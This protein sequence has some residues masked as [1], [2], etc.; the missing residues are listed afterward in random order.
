MVENYGTCKSWKCTTDINCSRHEVNLLL[1][2]HNQYPCP[3]VNTNTEQRQ[4]ALRTL[5]NS[6]DRWQQQDLK[7]GL[8]LPPTVPNSVCFT[9][10]NL[11]SCILVHKNNQS[12]HK[13]EENNKVFISRINR[14]KDAAFL[15]VRTRGAYSFNGVFQSTYFSYKARRVRQATWSSEQLCWP[16]SLKYL[17]VYAYPM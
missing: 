10:K 4:C 2:E 1:E 12:V 15:Y 6:A 13:A 8:P 16:S 11:V 14:W 3:S 5:R 9:V 17:V 7:L